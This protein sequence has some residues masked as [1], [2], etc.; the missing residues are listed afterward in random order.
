MRAPFFDQVEIVRAN[1]RAVFEHVPELP[2]TKA[3]G[4]E[5][6]FRG[7]EPE[8]AA[9][10][11]AL[12]GLGYHDAKRIVTSIRPVAERTGPRTAIHP[13]TGPD[14]DHGAGGPGRARPPG[15]P[16]RGVQPVRQVHQRP[17]GWRATDVPVPAQSLLLDRIAAVLGAAPMLAEHLVRYP[18]A[19]EGLLSAEDLVDAGRLLR[20]RIAGTVN[21]EDVI[22]IVRRAVKERDFF[23]SVATLEG[24]MDA[25]TAGRQRSAWPKPLY[26]SWCPAYCPVAPGATAASLAAR[27]RSWR[28]ARPAGGR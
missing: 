21:L 16:R 8:P 25:D 13:S 17:A 28:W 5:L 22:Q 19:L 4:P 9:T 6:D 24:R 18:S 1:Y 23:L 27:L 14:D 15:R 10:V 3:V 2:G 12:N 7:D 26:P 11:A 20:S